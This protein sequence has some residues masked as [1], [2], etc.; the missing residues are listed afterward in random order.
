MEDTSVLVIFNLVQRVDAAQDF[1]IL[2]GTVGAVDCDGQI[3]AW[4]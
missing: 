2:F 3:H 1:D 4:L